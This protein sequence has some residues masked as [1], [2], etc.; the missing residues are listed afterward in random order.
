MTLPLTAITNS[1]LSSWARACA[2]VL[3]FVEDKLGDAVAVT[4]MDEN[5]TAQIAPPVNPA[6]E[7]NRFS[8]IGRPQSSAAMSTAHLAEKV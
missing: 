4:Q 3:A 6:H 2:S 1:E 8:D 5:H 7:K